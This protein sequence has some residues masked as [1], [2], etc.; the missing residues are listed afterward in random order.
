M[1]MKQSSSRD[2]NHM[3]YQPVGLCIES[4]TRNTARYLN[5]PKLY[6][7]GES[8]THTETKYMETSLKDQ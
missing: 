4:T 2:A 3:I 8:I 7:I 6:I 5:K 1:R